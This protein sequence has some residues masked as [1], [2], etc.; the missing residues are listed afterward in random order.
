MESKAIKK[1]M[2]INKE[3]FGNEIQCIYIFLNE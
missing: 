1:Q 2:G 3:R